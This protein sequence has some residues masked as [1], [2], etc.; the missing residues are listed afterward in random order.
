MLFK[1]KNTQITKVLRL[2]VDNTG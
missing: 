2:M 1:I